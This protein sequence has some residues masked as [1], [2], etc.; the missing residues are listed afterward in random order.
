MKKVI[1]IVRRMF[2]FTDG[3]LVSP[4]EL[5]KYRTEVAEVL[6]NNPSKSYSTI[7][8]GNMLVVAVRDEKD[9]TVYQAERYKSYTYRV[10]EV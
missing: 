7:R 5:E 3:A 9:I 2:D 1:E 4:G 8:T 10:E 6:A